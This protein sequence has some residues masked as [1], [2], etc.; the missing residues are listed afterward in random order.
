[1]MTTTVQDAPRDMRWTT[2]NMAGPN[3]LADWAE[4][5]S[6]NIAEMHVESPLRSG[7][8]A[9]WKRIGM[10]PI[11]L[12]FLDASPQ[13]VMRTRAMAQRQHSASYQL[14]YIQKGPAD[15]RHCGATLHIPEGSFVLLDNLEPY[16]LSFAQ[17]SS[18]VTIHFDD[19]WLRKWVAYPRALAARLI[20]GEQTWA[21]P[22]AAMLRTISAGGLHGA[23][24]PRSVIADQFGALLALMANE[25]APQASRYQTEVLIRFKRALRERFEDST[26]DPAGFARQMGVSKRHLH[27]SFAQAGTTFGAELL[28]IRLAH[29]AQ[30]LNDRRFVSHR[31]QD[32][33]WACG[34]ADPSHFA[35]R[36]REKFGASPLQ[37]REGNEDSGR[38]RKRRDQQRGPSIPDPVEQ[39]ANGAPASKPAAGQEAKRATSSLLPPIRGS[40]AVTRS[41]PS[42]VL[43]V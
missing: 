6:Q 32:I 3:A 18:C 26:L 42:A 11:D 7:F 14:L 2:D 33:A 17:D 40:S 27:G 24:L 20:V 28:E 1:M 41:R 37:Y 16:D 30:L 13:R 10:G 9:T 4:L 39:I 12:N 8:K 38:A 15:L 23:V 43:R 19:R 22:L 25:D 31:V 35:R 29:A 21:A 5:L 34:F 36:F